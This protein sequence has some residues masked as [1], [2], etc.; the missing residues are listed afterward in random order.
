MS[1]DLICPIC[2]E[3]TRVYMG[4]A[5]K[6]R[7][8]G[9]HADMLKAEEIFLDSYGRW[10]ETAT[11][12]VLSQEKAT[13]ARIAY[14]MQKPPQSE[15]IAESDHMCIICGGPSGKKEVCISCY[16]DIMHAQNDLDKNKK[17]WELKDYYYNLKAFIGRL[18][19]PE[20]ITKNLYK[21]YAIAW[22]LKNLYK[23]NQ[24]AETVYDDVKILVKTRERIK[25]LNF[26]AEQQQNDKTIIA[27]ADIEKNR[28]SDGHICKSEGEVIIDDILFKWKVCHAY[29]RRVKE[30]P[31]DKERTIIA[32]WFVPLDGY[33]GIYIEYWGMDKKDYQ[34]NKEEKLKLYEKYSNDVKLIQINK[35]DINDRQN[36]EDR[37]YQELKALGWKQ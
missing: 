5:R 37:I 17:P 2:G 11:Q 34:D 20:E 4:N 22:L 6:D 32:D 19:N 10:R 15:P 31:T 14:R 27:V 8:C 13:P 9:K 24:L 7:L 1:N 25:K 26:T 23:E 36:L 3:P 21:L 30:I 16:S 29:E 18:K 12:N 35:N 28:A 33:K